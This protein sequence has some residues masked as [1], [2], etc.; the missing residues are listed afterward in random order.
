M[1]LVDDI[2]LISCSGRCEIDFLKDWPDIVYSVI[3]SGVH[4]SNIK[5]GA[6]QDPLTGG[7]L[8]AGI[9]VYGMLTVN[10]SGKDLGDRSLTCTVLSAEKISVREL[11]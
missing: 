6:V 5:N 1:D 11:L 10:A 2:N 7:T 9:A 8:V 4:L 3:G